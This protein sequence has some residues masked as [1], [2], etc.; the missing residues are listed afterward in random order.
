MDE[1]ED[2]LFVQKVYGTLYPE[3]PLFTTGD[4]LKLLLEHPEIEKI[5]N[6]FERNEGYAKSLIMDEAYLASKKTR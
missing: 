5:N 4:I 3:N 6:A 2:F 1:P